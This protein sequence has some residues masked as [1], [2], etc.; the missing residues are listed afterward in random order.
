MKTLMILKYLRGPEIFVAPVD[1]IE[2]YPIEGSHWKASHWVT[3]DLRWRDSAT[4]GDPVPLE[5]VIKIWATEPLKKIIE[6]LER[7]LN[8]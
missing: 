4:L 5:G 6:R 3:S 2:G 8:T 7:A 1:L